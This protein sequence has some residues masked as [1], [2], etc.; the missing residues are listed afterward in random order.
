MSS[1]YLYLGIYTVILLAI[2][3]WISRRQ[4]KEDF[5]ISG[6]NRGGWQIFASKFAASIGAGYFITYTGF[7]YEYGTGVYTL[8]LGAIAGYFIFAYWASPRI[9]SNSSQEK[10]YTIG[11]FV[12]SKTNNKGTSYIA[13][14]LSIGILFSWLIV[15]IIGGGKIISDFGFL[16]Y[17]IAVILTASVVLLYIMLAGFRGVII[18]DVIQSIII[19]GLLVLV[20]F[21]IIGSNSLESL[22][23][24]KST[25]NFGVAFG[26]FLYGVLAVFAS[27]DRYQLCYAAKNEKKLKH[28]I[29]LAVIPI[30]LSATLLLMLGVFMAQ[31]SPGLDSAL[32][33]TEA[34]KNFLPASLL[35]LA[36]VLFFAG[37]MSSADTGIFSIASHYALSMKEK[38]VKTVRKSIIVVVIIITILAIIFPDIVNVSIFAGGVTLTL[39]LPMIYILLNGKKAKK[40]ISS[41]IGG[42]IG[43][44]L[45]ILFLG[46]EPSIAIPVLIISA[47][48]LLWPS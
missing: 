13:N 22:I 6:R 16:S 2:S 10:R 46:L 3:Y 28:G 32:V 47:I 7:A 19:F 34:L 21:S 48:G 30:I 31:N 41:V 39:S 37:I 26:F 45:G 18:T 40:F 38:S 42:L 12:Q 23:T 24:S 36:I 25:I 33:F 1:I 29:G 44:A 27:A 4:S 20:T 11:D 8:L 9:Y 43:L 35:P 17:E 14:I 5:L 15:G